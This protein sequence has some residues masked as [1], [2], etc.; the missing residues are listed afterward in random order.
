VLSRS[1]LS[2]MQAWEEL[3]QEFEDDGGLR[4]IYAM[5][6]DEAA[7]ERAYRF[8]ITQP[9]RVFRINDQEE[10]PP[11]TAKLCIG[12]RETA[13]PLLLFQRG[14]IEFA[15][16]FFCEEEIELD[17]WPCAIDGQEGLDELCQFITELGRAAGRAIDVT[18]ENEPDRLIL[19]YDLALDKVIASPSA[20]RDSAQ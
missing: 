16:H 11:S 1:R 15:C 9:S 14:A 18:H 13:S 17:F 10:T 2:A 5:E 19:R 6:V 3:C 20:D 4:D 8:L 7:W 12:L